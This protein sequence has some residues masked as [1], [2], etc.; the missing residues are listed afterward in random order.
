[1]ETLYTAREVARQL[2]ISQSYVYLLIKLKELIPSRA[3]P[4]L[5]SEEEVQRYKE[6]HINHE[7]GGIG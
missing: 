7:E 5:F 4:Y 2:D 1:M 6:N 3:K